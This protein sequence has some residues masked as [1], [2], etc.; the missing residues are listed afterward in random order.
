MLKRALAIL[1]VTLATPFATSEGNAMEKLTVMISGGFSLAYKQILPEF[2]RST[3]MTVT[4]L[5]GASQ[6]T[7]PKT[8]KSQLEQGVG[9]DVVILSKEGLG[10]LIAAGRIAKGSEVELASTP[11][12][13][14]VRQGSPKP[15][16]S[17][18]DA[19]KRALLS[20]RLVALPA[21]T[22]GIFLKD[23]IFPKLAIADKVTSKLFARGIESTASLAAG[24][25][26]LAIGPVSELVN[27]P[28]I[29]IV[30]PLPD[31]VQL[32]QIFTAAIVG[33]S[34]SSEQAKQF[35]D[36]LASDQSTPA[37][38][39]SGMTPVGNQRKQ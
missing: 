24:E 12:G 7:G 33:T 25:A 8:I 11:L 38:R 28:G 29:E 34:R 4:T 30:G 18:V 31:E 26:D 2:E 14:A 21:S 3:G 16:V 1:A 5:S 39:N 23:E 13:A 9:V 32:V 6:G 10:E 20:A 37:I 27:Q 19:L 17:S 36:Y 22:S 15:D 35:I